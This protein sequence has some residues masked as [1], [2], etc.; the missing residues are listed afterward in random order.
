M[1][2]GPRS[3]AA[4]VVV[5]ELAL[6]GEVPTNLLSGFA[7]HR[8]HVRGVDDDLPKPPRARNV[9]V[10]LVDRIGARMSLRV[11]Q[12]VVADGP[13]LTLRNNGQGRL[14]SAGE[15]QDERPKPER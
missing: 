10:I 1:P 8:T 9:R 4:A 14:R 11:V 3:A 15:R 5:A 6:D 13:G 7:A 2:V 12:R